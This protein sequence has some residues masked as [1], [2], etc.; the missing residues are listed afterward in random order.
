MEGFQMRCRIFSRTPGL[1][2]TWSIAPLSCDNEKCLHTLPNVPWESKLT[3]VKNHYVGVTNSTKK[4]PVKD[5]ISYFRA[6]PN[7]NWIPQMASCYGK[8]LLPGGIN[9]CFATCVF[10]LGVELLFAG[11]V[12]ALT[13]L[14][15]GFNRKWKQLQYFKALGRLGRRYVDKSY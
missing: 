15:I 4:Y 11:W 13:F 12:V 3:P 14:P 10:L 9:H 2:P 5:E 7:G 8:F 1:L 6:G